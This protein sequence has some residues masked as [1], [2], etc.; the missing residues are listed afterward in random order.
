MVLVPAFEYRNDRA[1][2]SK[3]R[4]DRVWTG[5]ESQ[6][7]PTGRADW[8]LKG[9]YRHNNSGYENTNVRG[10]HLNSGVRSG[11]GLNGSLYRHAN[12]GGAGMPGVV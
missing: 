3:A 9:C 7:N 5:D 8:L 11:I 10:E 4:V 2:S 6:G 12:P 1:S